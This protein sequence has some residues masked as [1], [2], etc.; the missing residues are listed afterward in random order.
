MA[1]VLHYRGNRCLF[2]GRRIVGPDTDGTFYLPVTSGYDTA[3]D[4]T[5]IG[6]QVVPPARWPQE[7]LLMRAELER[8]KQLRLTTLAAAG[9]R[10]TL[11][12]ITEAAMTAPAPAPQPEGRGATGKPV[13]GSEI[14]KW[15]H[16]TL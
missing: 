8:K 3:T 15:L 9:H 13:Q 4:T 10:K 2:D 11:R 6:F 1:D 7:T 12:L 5:T 14:G 16:A